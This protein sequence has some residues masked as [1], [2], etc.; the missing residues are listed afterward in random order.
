MARLAQRNLFHDKTRFAV[1]LT[2]IAFAIVLVLIQLG[3]FL[4]F[5]ISTSGIIDHSGADVWLCARGVQYFEVGF[6]IS[7]AHLYQ[8]LSVDGVAEAQPLI[9]R[10]TNWRR[11]DGAQK[12]VEVIGFVPDTGMG[13]PWNIV[14][15]RVESLREQN[16]VMVDEFYAAELGISRIGDVVE[17]QGFRATVVGFTRGIRSFTTTPFVF[18]SFKNALNYTASRAGETTYILITAD[19]VTDPVT[20]SR[21]ISERIPAIDAHTTLEFSRKTRMYWLFTTGA[22]VALLVA[23]V[24]G[25]IVGSVIVGQT[26]YATTVDHI[27]DFGIL[28]A[29]GASDAYLYRVIIEQALVSAVIGY[30]FAMVASFAI[31]RLSRTAG[32]MIMAPWELVVTMFVAA[33]IMC[34]SAAVISIHKVTRLDPAM[35]FKS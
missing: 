7:E 20:L 30:A 1:T 29:I 16:T 35:V 11:P 33:I 9:V 31:L 21:R 19:S 18:T 2:G 10:F 6:P 12:N 3:L 15:G 27:R 23:A 26:I 24:L 34:V 8:A 13:M 14:A 17:I 5:T 25:L 22:G 32:A 4:G 28:K